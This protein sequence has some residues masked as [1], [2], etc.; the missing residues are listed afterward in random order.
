MP[1]TG[2]VVND[3]EQVPGITA[4]KANL[5]NVENVALTGVPLHFGQRRSDIIKCGN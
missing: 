4:K 5:V 2:Q 3:F 1:P